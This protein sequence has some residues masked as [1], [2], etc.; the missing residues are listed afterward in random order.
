MA[1]H[2]AREYPHH[3]LRTLYRAHRAVQGARLMAVLPQGHGV[4]LLATW[5][6]AVVLWV[7]NH[8]ILDSADQSSHYPSGG[9]RRQSWMVS[10]RGMVICRGDIC[11]CPDTGWRTW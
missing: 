6:P 5:G 8:W 7:G 4:H 10:V 2:S 11:C 9:I 1:A 3:G